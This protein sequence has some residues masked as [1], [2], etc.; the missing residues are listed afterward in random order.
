MYSIVCMYR[1]YY[2]FSMCCSCLPWIE[3]MNKYFLFGLE[4]FPAGKKNGIR[5]LIHISDNHGFFLNF[6]MKK[7]KSD[8]GGGFFTPFL[9][10]YTVTSY[11][12]PYVS[13]T[14]LKV[15]C[16]VYA[17]TAAYTWQVTFYKVPDKQGHVYLVRLYVCVCPHTYIPSKQLKR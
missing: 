12:W 10:K 8:Q 14:L 3:K 13:C 7:I 6:C 15:T 16:P 4:I 17:C 2:I 9:C 1:M 5:L 11:T